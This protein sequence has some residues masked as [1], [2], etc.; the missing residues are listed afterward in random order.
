MPLSIP[1]QS[2]EED[3]TNKEVTNRKITNTKYYTSSRIR[4]TNPSRS[5]LKSK[6]NV[7]TLPSQSEC[8]TPEPLHVENRLWQFNNSLIDREEDDREHAEESSIS[9]IDNVWAP[10]FSLS[11][12]SQPG[13]LTFYE[14]MQCKLQHLDRQHSIITDIQ[15]CLLVSLIVND[16]K[17]YPHP[18]IVRD[19]KEYSWA[20]D[21]IKRMTLC[22]IQRKVNNTLEYWVVQAKHNLPEG[23]ALLPDISESI[24]FQH[25]MVIPKMSEI[26]D[27]LRIHHVNTGHR[28]FKELYNK[29]K[30]KYHYIS[31]DMCQEYKKRCVHCNRTSSIR[32]HGK[33]P[34]HPIDGKDTFHHMQ[35]DLIDFRTSPAGPENQYKFVAHLI[36]HFSTFHITEAIEDKNATTILHFLRKVFSFLG[37][38]L[39]LHTD[40]GSEFENSV[41]RNYLASQ[42]IE[43]RHGKPYKPTTQ[44]KIERA[45]RTLQEIIEKLVSESNYTV[46]WYDVLYEA[47]LACNTTT[48]KSINKSPYEHIFCARPM[49]DGNLTAFRGTMS[50][51]SR[52]R[53]AEE[54]KD[55]KEE[56]KFNDGY[57]SDEVTTVNQEYNH[58][59][60]AKELRTHSKQTAENYRRKM[61]ESHDRLRKVQ[62]FE[63]GEI[64][65]I[66]IPKDYRQREANKLPAIVL[67]VDKTT[68]GRSIEDTYTLAYG[69]YRIDNVYYQHELIKL[70]SDQD[71]FDVVAKDMTRKDYVEEL[72]LKFNTNELLSQPLQSAY[73]EY[74]RALHYVAESNGINC[75]EL[76]DDTETDLNITN[77]EIDDHIFKSTFMP[78]IITDK[79]TNGKKLITVKITDTKCKVC[80]SSIADDDVHEVCHNCGCKMHKRAKCQFGDVQIYF[81]NNFYCSFAC[82]RR[83]RIYEVKII[84]ENTRTKQYTLLYN[85]GATGKLSIS[86]VESLAQY[87]KMVHDWRLAHPIVSLNN[88]ETAEDDD[89]QILSATITSNTASVSCTKPNATKDVCCVCNEELKNENPHNCYQCKRLMHGHII[90]PQRHLIYAADDWLYCNACKP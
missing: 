54:L 66:L 58:N 28:S 82:F 39:V 20:V 32:D 80:Y 21:L 37:F 35:L 2:T 77:M 4:R 23:F 45:N 64:A 40:N 74:I 8:S 61:K 65:G 87:A 25:Y 24:L 59:N 75:N 10:Q 47:T 90:C 48:S 1:T 56:D 18:E 89:I 44:G 31:R 83:Q 50:K 67:Q 53:V 88:A 68:A 71:Y 22:V 41:V 70:T 81:R 85:N 43:F 30:V 69:K 42:N 9:T 19:P 13:K 11:T 86:K 62:V 36:D 27:I 29:T 63:I 5:Q 60:L 16:P 38:P 52:K 14:W 15:H 34:I 26:E 84:A 6:R 72:T 3:L 76:V 12:K 79:N 78:A 73:N 33:P 17:S 49:N 7:Y 46:S 57:E 55:S 51:V